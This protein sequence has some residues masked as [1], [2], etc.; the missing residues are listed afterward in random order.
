LDAIN[1]DRIDVEGEDEENL[2]CGLELVAGEQSSV[3]TNN[4]EPVQRLT[5]ALHRFLT[6]LLADMSSE[7]ARTVQLLTAL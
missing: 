2:E 5:F 7:L 1:E 6:G 4:Q 3:I